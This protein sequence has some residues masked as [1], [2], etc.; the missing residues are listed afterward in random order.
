MKSYAKRLLIPLAGDPVMEFFTYFH[1]LI[2][3]G[4]MRVVIG[5]R[6]PYIEFS[7]SQIV[8]ENIAIPNGQ[9]HRLNNPAFFYDE[10]RSKDI[11]NIK[12]YHQKNE[13]A[14]ADYKVGYW[15]ICPTLLATKEYSKL[16]LNPNEEYPIMPLETEKPKTLWDVL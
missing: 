9:K 6:G 5:G 14:Y 3:K 4:F 8:H 11:S 2:A 7:D 12:I 1:L 16:L 10:Y 15:Y 13:V